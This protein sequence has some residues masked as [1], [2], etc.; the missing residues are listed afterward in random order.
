MKK[1]LLPLSIIAGLVIALCLVSPT[2]AV[3][4]DGPGMRGPE[5]HRVGDGPRGE[6]RGMRGKEIRRRGG[7]RRGEN[8][9]GMDKRQ[10]VLAAKARFLKF[11]SELT[12]TVKDPYQSIGF[13]ALAIKEYYSRRGE[14][15]KAVAELE[16]I[17]AK[18]KD[19]KARNILLFVIRQVH[20]RDRN[21]DN[22]LK[23]NQRIIDENISKVN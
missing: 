10:G 8:R 11:S 21:P 1:N 6:R 22:F 20:E 9:P 4:Q 18:T 13:A 19:Q 14:S 5:N 23:V 17:L 7:A 15:E 3:S 2:I 12:D 16:E